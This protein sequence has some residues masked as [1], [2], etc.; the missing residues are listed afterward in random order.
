VA[1][2]GELPLLLRS[3]VPVQPGDLLHVRVP[4]ERVA[5][6]AAPTGGA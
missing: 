2:D 1:G 4:P 5:V 6:F 3:P